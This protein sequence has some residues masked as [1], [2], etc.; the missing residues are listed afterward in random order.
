M[1]EPVQLTETA[2]AHFLHL[3]RI[4]DFEYYFFDVE[5]AIAKMEEEPEASY[6]RIT[7]H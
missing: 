7:V 1:S 5:D 4:E 3:V 2:K 6:E